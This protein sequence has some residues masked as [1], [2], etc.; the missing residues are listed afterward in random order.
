MKCPE[1]RNFN[2]LIHAN[3]ASLHKNNK[4]ES[5]QREIEPVG[6]IFYA[7]SWHL[8][9]W[10]YLRN[11]YRDFKVSNILSIHSTEIPFKKTEHISI[12][13][14]MKMLPVNY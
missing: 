10:C 6:L 7:F 2:S 12:N 9:A 14:Y 4:Q 1:V 5:S 13:D 11:E 8:I 3:E